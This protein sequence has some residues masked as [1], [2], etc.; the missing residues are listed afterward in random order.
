MVDKFIHETLTSGL[1]SYL[2]MGALQYSIKVIS[3]LFIEKAVR[4]AVRP[5]GISS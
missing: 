4:I 3:S 2:L 1:K 5:D